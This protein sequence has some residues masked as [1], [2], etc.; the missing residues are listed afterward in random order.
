MKNFAA[1]TP[2][3]LLTLYSISNSVESF[4]I[5]NQNSMITIHYT[6]PQTE[7]ALD[8]SDNDKYFD[9]MGINETPIKYDVKLKPSKQIRI[10][11]SFDSSRVDDIKASEFLQKLQTILNDP[12]M[13]LL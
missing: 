13:L 12:D 1:D 8:V 11:I 10:S 4:P 7:V 9:I 3:S 6:E 2:H 5:V